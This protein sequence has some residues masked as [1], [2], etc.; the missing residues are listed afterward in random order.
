MGFAGGGTSYAKTKLLRETG[1]CEE[2]LLCKRLNMKR[3]SNQQWDSTIDWRRD[4]DRGRNSATW[5]GRCE[6]CNW[7]KEE[8][9]KRNCETYIQN[10]AVSVYR[11]KSSLGLMWREME[12]SKLEKLLQ[13][14]R[15]KAAVSLAW[16]A[17]TG[18]IRYGI[19]NIALATWSSV[20]PSIKVRRRV[21]IQPSTGFIKYRK[22]KKRQKTLGF[23]PKKRKQKEY[24]W[25]L[26]ADSDVI[27][28]CFSSEDYSQTAHSG[29]HF[30]PNQTSN[31]PHRH[32]H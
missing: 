6:V 13:V 2:G 29:Y 16:S 15:K 14:K 1:I 17:Q 11:V 19:E 23:K 21:Y 20:C 24:V 31:I 7:Q 18:N 4:A 22:L 27:H 3:S 32:S 28:S 10:G 30:S 12:T 9:K 5:I 25:I 26:K 8:R